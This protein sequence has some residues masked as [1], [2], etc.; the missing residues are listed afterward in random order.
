MT[1][2][3]HHLNINTAKS[4][5]NKIFRVPHKRCSFVVRAHDEDDVLPVFKIPKEPTAQDI[6][7]LPR[8]PALAGVTIGEKL[9]RIHKQYKMQEEGA[10]SAMEEQLYSDN[11]AGGEYVGKQWNIMTF[12]LLTSFVV[13]VLGL[14]F[15]YFTYGSLWGNVS[16]Y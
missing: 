6:E 9:Q 14:L 16:Y 7:K 13:P 4:C 8:N 11:W 12:V 15:A 1:I 5:K 10:V 2:L 3:K